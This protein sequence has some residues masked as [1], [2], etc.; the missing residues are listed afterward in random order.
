V[1][2]V[3]RTWHR[4]DVWQESYEPFLSNNSI[5]IK[6]HLRQ[7]EFNDQSRCCA[8]QMSD[9]SDSSVAPE[10]KIIQSP[11]AEP[12]IRRQVQEW[13]ATGGKGQ[14]LLQRTLQP[15]DLKAVSAEL[16]AKIRLL[17]GELA[18][19]DLEQAV[20]YELRHQIRE[21]INP[22]TARREL[23]TAL[24]QFLET[25][26]RQ[27][28]AV[29]VDKA[30]ESHWREPHQL[31]KLASEAGLEIHQVLLNAKRELSGAPETSEP[32][33]P[34]VRR[35]VMEKIQELDE[36]YSSETVFARLQEAAGVTFISDLRRHLQ[37]AEQDFLLQK[38]KSFSAQ[39]LEEL[40]AD[41]Y[42]RIHALIDGAA[43]DAP[44]RFSNP[45]IREEVAED[46][47]R[48]RHH[49]TGDAAQM[50]LAQEE[51]STGAP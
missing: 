41:H 42:Q 7:K 48:L 38:K 20:A 2:T 24:I 9:E 34:S 21:A 28:I 32:L 51:K 22:Q 15:R 44:D 50:R 46:L 11:V 16:S 37:K 39:Q 6:V 33:D 8:H 31:E 23:V 27:C 40:R 14:E 49:F 12:V 36:E 45:A 18:P 43:A 1:K 19:E 3:H 5:E 30:L 26:L 29:A 25:D 35:A 13:I 10:A 4:L 17:V 47:R